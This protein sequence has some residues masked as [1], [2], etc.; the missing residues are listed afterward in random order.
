[1]PDDVSIAMRPTWAIAGLQANASVSDYVAT[2]D[3]GHLYCS[4]R[5]AGMAAFRLLPEI[6]SPHSVCPRGGSPSSQSPRSRGPTGRT[7]PQQSI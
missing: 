6:A 7:G 5:L 4:D 2:S 3:Y 1:M